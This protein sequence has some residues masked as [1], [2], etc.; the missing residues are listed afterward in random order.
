MSRKGKYLLG[1]CDNLISNKLRE[2]VFNDIGVPQL[3]DRC[4]EVI[5]KLQVEAEIMQQDDKDE[6]SK[7]QKA[8][9]NWGEDG[10]PIVQ[11]G[12]IDVNPQEHLQEADAEM[13]AQI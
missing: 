12:I 2:R 7:V 13:A 9:A 5:K 6:M 1:I 11:S 8:T 3:Q 4:L 10:R